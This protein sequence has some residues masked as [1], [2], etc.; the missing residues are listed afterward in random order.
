MTITINGVTYSIKDVP[1]ENSDESAMG[2]ASRME[3]AIRLF[4]PMADSQKAQ[5][6]LH[7]VFELLAGDCGLK[8]EHEMIESLAATLFAVLS[9]PRNAEAVEFITTA[10][11]I[12]ERSV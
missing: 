2:R 4:V 11:D 5:T 7:E 1:T 6:L 10:G 8:C 9:D 12:D 3:A